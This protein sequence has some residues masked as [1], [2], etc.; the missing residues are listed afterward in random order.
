MRLDRRHA[1]VL[2]ATLRHSVLLI[3]AGGPADSPWF[4]VPVGYRYTIGNPTVDWCFDG[5]PEPGLGGRVIRHPRGKVLAR[6]QGSG[7]QREPVDEAFI[8]PL[9]ASAEAAIGA[10]A[11]AAAQAQGWALKPAAAIT[12]VQQWLGRSA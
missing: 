6:M 4:K 1:T 7:S 11:F 3:E 2:L 12:E 9:M 8:A 10:A 5:E